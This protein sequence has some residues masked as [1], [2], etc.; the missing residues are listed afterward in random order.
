[1]P[2]DKALEKQDR[3]QVAP[4]FCRWLAGVRRVGMRLFNRL[5]PINF[6]TKGRLSDRFFFRNNSLP[7]V[8]GGGHRL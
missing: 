8:N 6:D 5:T 4:G 1:L 7:K 3:L 2:S